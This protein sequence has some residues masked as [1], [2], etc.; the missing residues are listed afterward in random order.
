MSHGLY[1][2]EPRGWRPRGSE[3]RDARVPI[4]ADDPEMDCGWKAIPLPPTIDDGWEIFD[5]SKDRKT[6]WRRWHLVEGS[7]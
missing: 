1:K 3:T 2:R 5:S 4:S 7:A 6:G